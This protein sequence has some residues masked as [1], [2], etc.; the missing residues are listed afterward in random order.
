[1]MLLIRMS[2]GGQKSTSYHG[3]QSHARVVVIE[4]KASVGKVREGEVGDVKEREVKE[5]FHSESKVEQW[6]MV[7]HG[8]TIWLS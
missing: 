8:I 1:M 7:E 3:T 4:S 2:A 6:S 5:H